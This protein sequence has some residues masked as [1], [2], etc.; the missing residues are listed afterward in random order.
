[1]AENRT[2]SMSEKEI[3]RCEI[4][5]MANERRI[6]QKTEAICPNCVSGSQ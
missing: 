2:V 5:R 3:K 1:M 6:T 4:L